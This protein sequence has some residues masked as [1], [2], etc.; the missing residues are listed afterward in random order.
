[1]TVST[2]TANNPGAFLQSWLD[3]S[4][5]VGHQL[6]TVRRALLIASWLLGLLAVASLAVV[7]GAQM[8]DRSRRV[9]ALKAIGATPR[10]VGVA[11]LGEYLAIAL[12]AAGVGLLAGF[13]LAPLITS[14]GA[15]LIGSPGAPSMT[16]ATVGWVAVL[17]IAVAALAAF[18]PSVRAA[19]TTTTAALA[20]AASAP[21]RR[22][23]LI[24]AAA[25][26]P[27]PLLLG[28]RLAARRPRRMALTTLSVMI[29]VTALVAVLTVHA[30]QLV[31]EQLGPYS[32][33]ADPH[34]AQTNEVLLVLSIVLVMLAAVNAVVVTWATAVDSRR[35]LAVARAVGASPA[36]V[37]T[38]LLAALLI[39][40]LPGAIAGVPLGVLLVRGTSQGGS[41]TI[42]PGSWLV[43]TVLGSLLA[44]AGLALLAAGVG[45]RRPAVETL[46][47]E[48][49]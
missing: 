37:R 12:V 2:P 46:Q 8:T 6:T 38:G 29:T 47:A 36:Q 23:L 42:P 16:A 44:L 48:L 40:A 5:E 20:D 45:A 3:V 27:V 22:A 19:R 39:P 34:L 26:L 33:L 7:V 32:A 43:A 10:L 4:K 15:G 28:L 9:G 49:A 17:A 25:R 21:K 30:H 31:R 24:A 14:P 41:V 1:M 13:L 11:L 35:P 18:V